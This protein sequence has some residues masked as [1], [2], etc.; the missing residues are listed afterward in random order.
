MPNLNDWRRFSKTKMPSSWWFGG[1]TSIR[2]DTFRNAVSHTNAY[3]SSV[4]IG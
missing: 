1:L 2:A 4:M 3:L